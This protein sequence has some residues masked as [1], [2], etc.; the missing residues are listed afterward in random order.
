MC[1]RIRKYSFNYKNN[2]QDYIRQNSKYL[3]ILAE[4]LIGMNSESC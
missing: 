1:M 3:D 2:I 4:L